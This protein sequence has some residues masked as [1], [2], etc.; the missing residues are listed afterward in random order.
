MPA[1]VHPSVYTSFAIAAF[2]VWRL[3]ARMRR[4]IG[5]QKLS[6]V[7]PWLTVTLF[8]LLLALLLL[9]TLASPLTAV[10][11]LS[12]A[13]LGVVLG[14]VG[15]RLTTFEVTPEGLFY[16]PNAHL[17][18]ALSLLLAVRVTWRYLQISMIVDTSTPGPGA[19]FVSS[20]LTL[21][22]FGTLAGYYVSYAIGLLRWQRQVR[23]GAVVM[24]E[25]QPAAIAAAPSEDG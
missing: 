22:I 13:A 5:R 12:G 20:P 9:G 15:H 18:I 24:T 23:A 7:R 6:N 3:Y 4:V 25:S 1:N 2:I 14:I 10:A 17:G 16:T 19:G 11:L 8:P 21:L